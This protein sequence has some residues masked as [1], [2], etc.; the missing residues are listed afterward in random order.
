M[1][2]VAV[3]VHPLAIQDRT[4]EFRSCIA[5]LSKLNN[6]TTASSRQGLLNDS[7][8]RYAPTSLDSDSSHTSSSSS[9]PKS[10]F[11]IRAASIAR[12]I[13]DTTAMLQ[14][15]A[16]LARRKTL[17]DDKPVEISELTFVI[18]Q[19]VSKINKSIADLQAYVKSGLTGSDSGSSAAAWGGGSSS[20]SNSKQGKKQLSEHANNVVVSLQG[21]LT[22]VTTGFEEV[23]EVRIKNI[24]ASKN[25]KDQ[26]ISAV[27]PNGSSSIATGSSGSGSGSAASSNVSGTTTGPNNSDLKSQ[28]QQNFSNH[29]SPLYSVSRARTPQQPVTSA[30]AAA[31]V[32][33]H[34]SKSATPVPGGPSLSENPYASNSAALQQDGSISGGAGAHTD[35]LALPEQQQTL[36]LLE[37]QHAQQEFQYMAQRSNAVEAI[38]STIQELGGIFQQLATMVSEQRET[39]QRID[40]DT[41]DISLNVS[42]A[43]RELLKYYA[44]I[45]SNRWLIIKSFGIILLFFFLWVI[46]S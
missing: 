6:A 45:S 25:R 26:F 35:Y 15:L 31:A 10:Q 12:E 16:L 30:A 2:T 9:S 14:R 34:G 39:I 23:L 27:A 11:A 8:S 28:D 17:F 19:K 44:R 20:G 32:S 37:E 38:E 29:D 42:G 41:E 36:A 46:V 24:Q 7:S 21:K 3:A 1:A 18:K 13:E 40:A 22:D 4:N 5:S 33:V 43:Q